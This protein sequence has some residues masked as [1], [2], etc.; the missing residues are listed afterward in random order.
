MFPS[1]IKAEV[2][3]TTGGG[4]SLAARELDALAVSDPGA[5]GLVA[6]LFVGADRD[7]D[8][9]WTIVDAADFHGRNGE[10]VS[11]AR[12][13]LVATARTQR[14]LDPLR[15]HVDELWPPF[16][17][18]FA[19]VAERGHTKLVAELDTLH[20]T[21]GLRERLPRDRV[22][23]VEHLATVKELVRRHGE[24]DAGR[25]AQDLIA[26]LLTLA[27]YRK[28]TL[29]PVGVPDFVLDDCAVLT[30]PCSAC[31]FS[32]PRS[33]AERVVAL[34]RAAGDERLAATMEAR[35]VA[36]G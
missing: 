33:D 19:D 18:A 25:L 35:M 31:R 21:G 22:L 3:L 26:Y 36:K 16:L 13:V 20:R 15:R 1:K 8:G 11:A 7:F 2:K 12:S 30:A 34:C 9:R 23:G 17:Q 10:S 14:W 32:L 24:S 5:V 29:N 6:V 4:V 28:V 27:G